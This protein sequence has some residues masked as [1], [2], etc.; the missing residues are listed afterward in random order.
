MTSFVT[1][2][3]TNRDSQRLQR[4]VTLS[5]LN[6]DQCRDYCIN[7]RREGKRNKKVGPALFLRKGEKSTDMTWDGVSAIIFLLK[8]ALVSQLQR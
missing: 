6:D 1:A 2:R 5:L 8:R 3:I 4:T 7:S